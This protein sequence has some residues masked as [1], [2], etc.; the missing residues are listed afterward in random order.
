MIKSGLTA[1]VQIP[2][3]IRVDDAGSR[4]ILGSPDL[5]EEITMNLVSTEAR[6]HRAPGGSSSMA[7]L[8]E[9]D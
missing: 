2:I 7:K 9:M 6:A 4:R 5:W 3:M 8:A 1:K